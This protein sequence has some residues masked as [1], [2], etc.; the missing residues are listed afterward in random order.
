[1]FV[2]RQGDAPVD[3]IEDPSKDLFACV[4]KSISLVQ[5]LKRNG[6]FL[7]SASDRWRWEDGVDAMK[8]G[9]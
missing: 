1:M 7:C 5:L 9:A 4:P 3:A 2:G 8:D 6:V